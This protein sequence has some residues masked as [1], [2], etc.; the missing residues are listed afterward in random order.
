MGKGGKSNGEELERRRAIEIVLERR[1]GW[2]VRSSA[3]PGRVVQ[4]RVATGPLGTSPR[5]RKLLVDCPGEVRWATG[6]FT[7]GGDFPSG[8]LGSWSL[9]RQVQRGS[10][11]LLFI[12]PQ[13]ELRPGPVRVQGS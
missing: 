5:P 8:L 6:V 13:I 1:V 2:S 3:Q 11:S 10:Y 4:F 12:T 7:L 9:Q